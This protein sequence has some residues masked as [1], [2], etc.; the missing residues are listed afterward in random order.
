M[1]YLQ[2]FAACSMSDSL[3]FV[4]TNHIKVC[5][6]TYPNCNMVCLVGPITVFRLSV[7]F[8]SSVTCLSSSTISDI[9]F[10]ICV[11]FAEDC[12]IPLFSLRLFYPTWAGCD[13][14]LL[15]CSR[16]S[17]QA[18]VSL[19]FRFF[20]RLWSLLL[21]IDWSRPL[22][23]FSVCLFFLECPLTGFISVR[24]FTVSSV[25][26]WLSKTH[27][28][29]RVKTELPPFTAVFVD[30]NMLIPFSFFITLL[31]VPWVDFESSLLFD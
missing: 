28:W 9:P 23:R 1:F 21:S 18:V 15:S 30:L 16:K 10:G 2:Q 11:S 20:L 6:F 13:S 5:N 22:F 14:M 12:I 8:F 4:Y 19:S 24:T 3:I 27:F 26:F 7:S 29:C 31:K 25:L 17:T